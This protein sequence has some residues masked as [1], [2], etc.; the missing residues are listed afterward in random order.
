MAVVAL[1][2]GQTSRAFIRYFLFLLTRAMFSS[3]G[4]IFC[5]VYNVDRQKMNE[6]FNWMN[7]NNNAGETSHQLWGAAA[8]AFDPSQMHFAKK[9]DWKE[10]FF[11]QKS[12]RNAWLFHHKSSSLHRG[13]IWS[14]L[15]VVRRCSA[16]ECIHRR[17]LEVSLTNYCNCHPSTPQMSAGLTEKSY[18]TGGFACNN[19]QAAS[20]ARF[21]DCLSSKMYSER[22][23]GHKILSGDG[24]SAT[25][26]PV[27]QVTSQRR[28]ADA[29]SGLTWSYLS[30]HCHHCCCNGQW[31]HHSYERLSWFCCCNCLSPWFG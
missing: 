11:S 19:C 10:K 12:W 29:P 18:Q 20:P 6:G 14:Q 21:C 8:V 1:V 31:C 25:C 23:V 24:N 15:L 2:D 7:N 26:W 3:S 27:G 28:A 30:C 16:L 9:K 17:F 5:T 22:T 4:T 13:Q